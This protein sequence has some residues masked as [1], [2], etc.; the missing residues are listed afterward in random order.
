M[1]KQLSDYQSYTL[2]DLINDKSFMLWVSQPTDELDIKWISIQKAYPSLTSIIAE[3]KR[4]VLSLR[5]EVEILDKKEQQEL[6]NTIA[7]RTTLSSIPVRKFRL[8]SS[9]AAAAILVGVLFA[10]GLLY[11]SFQQVTIQTPYGQ[12][13]IVNLPDGSKVTLNANSNIKYDRSWEDNEIR[14]VWIEGEAFLRVNHLHKNGPVK[15]HQR[16]VVHTGA[17][18]VEVIGTS[19]NVNDRRGRTE[20]ALLDGKISLVLRNQEEKSL[21]LVPGDIVEYAGGKLNK[22][23]TNVVEYTSWKDGKLYF[24]DVPL[25]KI[26]NYF[27]DIYGYKVSVDDPK[28]LKRRLSGTMSSKNE[29]VFFETIARTLNLSITPNK[30]SH[31]LIIKAK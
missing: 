16:F 15:D 11:S 14:E 10:V 18:N 21:I 1:K 27:E 13:Q 9:Y 30:A 5:F 20:V 2:N 28:I 26:F 23:P 7:A 4:I 3:A 25:S 29:M 24:R 6:W 22:K 17:L 12:M 19:F 31:E 8:W